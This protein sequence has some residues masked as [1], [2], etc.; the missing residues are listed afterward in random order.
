MTVTDDARPDRRTAARHRVR[1]VRTA[2]S[3]RTGALSGYGWVVLGST[4][5]ALVVGRRYGW[6]ELVVAG[7]V[8]TVAFVV[9]VLMTVG[10]SS[11]AVD[12][13]LADER[14]T[15]GQRAVGTL[16]VRNDGRRRLLPA[17]I[18][19]PVGAG[20]AS[21]ALPSMGPGAVH[22]EIF[23]IPT[24]RRAVVEVGPVRSV[25]GDPLGIA[26]REMRWTD[27]VELYVHPST[28]SLAG[29]R[30]GVLRDLEGQATRTVS[31]NDMS[32][33]A[34]RE[35]VP[36]D[37]RRNIHWRTS[38]RTGTLMVRQFEDTRRTHTALALATERP[39][40]AD[41]DEFELAVSTFASI[42]V[43][44][45]RDALEIT[46]ITG[47]STVRSR[48]PRVLLDD[49]AGVA[50]APKAPDARALAHSVA[51]LAPTAT[52]ALMVTGSVPSH[53]ELRASAVHIP[54][55]T[56]A[57]FVACEP[58]AEI[59][60][61]TQGTLSVATLGDITELPRLLRRLVAQ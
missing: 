57:V 24:A 36:G 11:Y 7:C 4:L 43:Q 49:C 5:A 27:P 3:A 29:T 14:V 38:A 35:Y 9:A 41:D 8:L 46:A 37:D 47:A 25:R 1:A 20:S 59:A 61:R 53:S 26:R 18:E 40:Y 13:D 22:E 50:L 48:T 23:A 55:G 2:V 32:F 51:R 19:L 39:D 60:L 28:V 16:V 33:H 21:F 54:A 52:L 10:R 6:E 31:D 17:Q 45:I 42:G 30:A 58:G 15:V 34:L 44:V 56:R 12:L